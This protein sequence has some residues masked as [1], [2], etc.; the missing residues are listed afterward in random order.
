MNVLLQRQFVFEQSSS[1][2]GGETKTTS[3]S[4]DKIWMFSVVVVAVNPPEFL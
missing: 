3:K 4:Q 2:S 1:S